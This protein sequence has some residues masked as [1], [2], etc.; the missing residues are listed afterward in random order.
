MIAQ[1][2]RSE[3]QFAILVSLVAIVGRGYFAPER[4][5]ERLAGYYDDPSKAA[6][7]LVAV[8]LAVLGLVAPL[9]A[10]AAMS[11]SSVIVVANAVRLGSGEPAGRS[12]IP[13]GRIY[14]H[15]PYGSG[16]MTDFFFLI[17]IAIGLGLIGLASFM[18]TLKN[19]QYDD[20][21]GS[22]RAI[23][24]EGDAGPLPETGNPGSHRPG[25]T[26]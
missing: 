5:N 18:W 11:L 9:I 4:S 1:L 22:G 19:G 23:L 2:T 21:Q 7:H 15:I 25:D 26:P 6:C 16:R 20:L 3:R 14:P 24:F 12:R 10:A 8:P 13:P 17:P